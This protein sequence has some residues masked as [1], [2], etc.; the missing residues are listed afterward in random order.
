M[1]RGARHATGDPAEGSRT[2]IRGSDL[3]AI[4]LSL[5]FW[6]SALAFMLIG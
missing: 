1:I 5:A 4:L 2:P 3:R 6:G